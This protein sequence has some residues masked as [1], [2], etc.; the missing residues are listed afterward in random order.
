MVLLKAVADVRKPT[1]TSIDSSAEVNAV[2]D[3]VVEV[4]LVFITKMYF[5]I[6]RGL[7]TR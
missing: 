1:P 4:G 6:D 3:T 5:A 2:P 7:A